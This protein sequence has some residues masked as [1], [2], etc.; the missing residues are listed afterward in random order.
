LPI[1]GIRAE[2]V[3]PAFV[4]PLPRRGRS[5]LSVTVRASA[6]LRLAAAGRLTRRRGVR[7]ALMQG[8]NH[9]NHADAKQII[10]SLGKARTITLVWKEI[11]VYGKK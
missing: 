7:E 6:T 4:L 2:F 3:K 5:K 8:N 10:I 1:A 11:N 9:A